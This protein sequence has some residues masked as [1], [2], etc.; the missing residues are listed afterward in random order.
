MNNQT[1]ITIQQAK[2]SQSGKTLGIQSSDGTWYQTK[3]WE[4]EQQI[5]NA[6][7]A[8]TSAS[9]FNGKTM[10]WINDYRL[11]EQAQTVPGHV[12]Q[13]PS[14]AP[15]PQAVTSPPA[16]QTAPVARSPV[17]PAPTKGIDRDASIVAQTLCKTVTFHTIDEAWAAYK[18]LY[19]GY[20]AW[21]AGYDPQAEAQSQQQQYDA[22][23]DE[24]PF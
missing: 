12:Q 11:P 8:D 17:T 4:L 14:M 1:M 7:Y 2:H 10:H 24:I 3:N 23:S 9:E 15:Q 18:Q 20:V 6:I 13:P 16:P 19:A 22:P 21:A 5:G